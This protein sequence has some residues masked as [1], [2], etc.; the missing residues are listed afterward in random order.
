MFRFIEIL[1]DLIYTETGVLSLTWPKKSLSGQNPGGGS[2][3]WRMWNLGSTTLRLPLS[4]FPSL[5]SPSPSSKTGTPS[6]RRRRWISSFFC[7]FLSFLFFIYFSFTVRGMANH[8]RHVATSPQL[9][10]PLHPRHRNAH[11]RCAHV[12]TTCNPHA[13]ATSACTT[14][15]TCLPRQVRASELPRMPCWRRRTTLEHD[16]HRPPASCWRV[17]SLLFYSD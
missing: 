4:L 11:S 13:G 15:A 16:H 6:R 7:F 17:M 10:A 3:L 2:N 14:R 9:A 5:S 8:H 1:F 12:T